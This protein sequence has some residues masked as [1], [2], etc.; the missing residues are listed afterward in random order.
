MLERVEA[1]HPDVARALRARSGMERLRL[2]HETWEMVRDRL[3]LYLAVRH[4]E[5]SRNAIQG[6]VARRLLGVSWS[7]VERHGSARALRA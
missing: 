5:W 2:A 1:V 4:P 7:S 3:A 6:Q